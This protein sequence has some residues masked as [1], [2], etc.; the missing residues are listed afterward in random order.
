M[1]VV[2]LKASVTAGS[3]LVVVITF[4]GDLDATG[5]AKV[6]DLLTAAITVS[7]SLI[8]LDTSK[9]TLIDLDGLA[10]LVAAEVRAREAGTRLVLRSPAK[11]VLDLLFLAG[12]D[13]FFTIGV[14]G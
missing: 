1:S 9:V 3:E 12:L 8:L 7:Y 4:E 2:D 13:N 6:A 5:A 14:N 11:R 10:G